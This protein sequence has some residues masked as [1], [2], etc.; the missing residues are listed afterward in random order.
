[1]FTDRNSSLAPSYLKS[2]LEQLSN[3]YVREVTSREIFPGRELTYGESSTVQTLNLSFYPT[4][5]G[6]YNLDTDN[7]DSEGNLLFPEKRWG[8]IMRKMDNTNFEQSNIEYVQFWLMDPFMDPDNPNQE[9]GDL[10]FNFG[11]MSEDILKDGLKSYE[12]GIP[13][14]GSDQYLTNT[15]WGRVST[16]NSLTYSF[17]N[18]TSSRKTQ[19]VGLNGL[20]TDDEFNFPTYSDY[21]DRL[22]AKLSP[23]AIETCLLYTSP[24]PRDRG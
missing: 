21:L 7:I 15:V 10:Y 12:N 9:G 13:I 14:D 19:D 2:D 3:P 4:E 5:R 18:N 11:E 6:P 16:Q 24:S 1:M 23:A 22:R 20:S 17:D 8:G